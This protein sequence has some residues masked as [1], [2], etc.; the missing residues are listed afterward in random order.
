DPPYYDAIPYSDLMDYFYIWQRRTLA[1]LSPAIDDAHAEE[2]SSKWDHEANDGELIDDASRHENDA[3]KSKQ[4]YE[5]GMARVFVQCAAALK[6][7]GRLVIVFANKQPDAWETLE[8]AI[9]RA[10]FV[11]DGS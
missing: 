1:G 6:P 3:A 9:I 4:V 5:D 7:E 2:L 10:G 8:S 11:V